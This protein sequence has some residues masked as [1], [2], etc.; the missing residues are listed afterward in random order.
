MFKIKYETNIDLDTIMNPY[1]EFVYPD[2]DVKI[3]I[4]IMCPF[5]CK[6]FNIMVCVKNDEKKSLLIYKSDEVHNEIPLFEWLPNSH[7]RSF[8]VIDPYTKDEFLINVGEGIGVIYI[9][10]MRTYIKLIY[11]KEDPSGC[12]PAVFAED[13]DFLN[14]KWALSADLNLGY[15]VLYIKKLSFKSEDCSSFEPPIYYNLCEKKD[16]RDNEVLSF[17][18]G[19]MLRGKYNYMPLKYKT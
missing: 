13:K 5:G 3:K 7:M 2:F 19:D 17:N 9:E 18:Y 1:S 15:D 16:F 12:F 4:K 14:I 11:K 8:E 6:N 10:E